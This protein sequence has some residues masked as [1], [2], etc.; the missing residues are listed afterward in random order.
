MKPLTLLTQ[1]T[2]KNCTQCNKPFKD[3]QNVTVHIHDIFINS[4]VK[5]KSCKQICGECFKGKYFE[6][7]GTFSNDL[8]QITCA[9]NFVVHTPTLLSS[10]G[11]VFTFRNLI[12]NHNNDTPKKKLIHIDL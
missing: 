7:V 9:K 5:K 3:V 4:L 10:N 8:K 11:I 6:K 1:L 12:N 2:S